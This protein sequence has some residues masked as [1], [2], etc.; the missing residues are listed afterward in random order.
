V[1]SEQGGNTRQYSLTE[2]LLRKGVIGAFLVVLGL[3]TALAGFFSD[4]GERARHAK[5]RRE[6]RLL[7]EQ[8]S[9]QR[10][11]LDQLENTLRELQK[12][13]EEFRVLAGLDPL[14]PEV[15]KGGMGGSAANQLK[16]PPLD[17]A[18]SRA[19]RDESLDLDAVTQR[20]RTLR[21]SWEEAVTTLQS[22]RDRLA[23][24]P[25]ILPT[26]GF[27]S[28]QFSRQ[29]WHPILDDNR[30]HAG[31]DIAAPTGTPIYAPARGRVAFVGNHG[32]YGLL[33]ELHHGH[34]YVT[35]YAHLSRANVRVG[36][37]VNRRAVI[38]EVGETGLAIGPHL[39]YEVLVNGEPRNPLGFVFDKGAIPD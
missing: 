34:G 35:R 30:P 4:A 7:D 15:Y 38:G 12:R 18:L 32:Q 22:K 19:L 39:H 21:T 16:G 37:T 2:S 27:L 26:M 5:L 23:A 6:N 1:W 36:E 33:V 24:T 13:D 9:A 25:S 10:N 14:A 17:S 20:V 29:R 31:I 3:S 11:A 28:S 8:L